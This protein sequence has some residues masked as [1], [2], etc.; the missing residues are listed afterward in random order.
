MTDAKEK[1][2]Q[3]ARKDRQRKQYRIDFMG[4]LYSEIGIDDVPLLEKPD[5]KSSPDETPR[6]LEAL[7]MF[8]SKFLDD[9]YQKRYE[10]ENVSW[11]KVA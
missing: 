4:K 3:N 10:R 9:Y 11:I 5:N 8:V 2:S 7:D 1:N 6:Y